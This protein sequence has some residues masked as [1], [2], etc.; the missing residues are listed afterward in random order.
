MHLISYSASVHYMGNPV[1]GIEIGFTPY[2]KER[3]PH[4]KL[5]FDQYS[6]IT[7]RWCEIGCKFVLF[8]QEVVHRLST[9][10]DFG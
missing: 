6:A 5:Q 2:D 9:G 7:W 4:Q 1:Q 10:T 8:K 3:K